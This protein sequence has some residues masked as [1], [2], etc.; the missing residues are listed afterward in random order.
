MNDS[1]TMSWS[2]KILSANLCFP[3]NNWNHSSMLSGLYQ[4][5]IPLHMRW[6]HLQI[7]S[8]ELSLDFWHDII[9]ME[10]LIQCDRAHS[11]DGLMTIQDSRLKRIGSHGLPTHLQPADNLCKWYDHRIVRNKSPVAVSSHCFCLSD[12]KKFGRLVIS[13]QKIQDFGIDFPELTESGNFA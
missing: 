3:Y 11:L 7:K 12:G 6:Q 8:T 4:V 1:T 9:H 10:I 13:W 2:Y 5:V